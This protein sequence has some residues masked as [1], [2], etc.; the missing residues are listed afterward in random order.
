MAYTADML[1]DILTD[2]T[3]TNVDYMAVKMLQ[4]GDVSGMWMGFKWTPFEGIDP[5]SSSTYYTIA[6]AKSGMHV[7]SGFVEGKSQRR[8]DKKDTMQVSM[9]ASIGAI[10]ADEKKVVEIAFQ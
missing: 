7:G 8:A 1:E 5:V 6:W 3:L 2:T 9:A 4:E 10:R